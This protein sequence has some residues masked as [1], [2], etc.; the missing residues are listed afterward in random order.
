MWIENGKWRKEKERSNV[1][2]MVKKTKT[3]KKQEKNLTI[4]YIH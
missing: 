4:Y 1:Y 2:K 3:E